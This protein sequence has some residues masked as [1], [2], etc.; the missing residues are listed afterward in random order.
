MHSGR[1]AGSGCGRACSHCSVTLQMTVAVACA[2]ENQRL[3]NSSSDASDQV[4][5][6]LGNLVRFTS[7]SRLPEVLSE[8]TFRLT[9]H[10]RIYLNCPVHCPFT[11]SRWYLLQIVYCEL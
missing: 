9:T 2:P 1:G 5:G 8:R 4:G 6:G 10:L 7:I 11:E 3:Q